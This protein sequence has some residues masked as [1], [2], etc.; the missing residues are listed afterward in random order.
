MTYKVR[1]DPYYTKLKN[2]KGW[3]SCNDPHL[4]ICAL[5]E[6]N[7]KPR[8]TNIEKISIPSVIPGYDFEEILHKMS[9]QRTDFVVPIVIERD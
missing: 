1:L 6:H 5:W 7:D 8:K 2:K 9:Y 3:V 4:L